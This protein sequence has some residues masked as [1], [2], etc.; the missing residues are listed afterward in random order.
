M[1]ITLLTPSA[2]SVLLG[3]MRFL[4]SSVALGRAS[5]NVRF[6]ST[7]LTTNKPHVDNAVGWRSKPS[8][9]NHESHT[10]DGGG[11]AHGLVVVCGPGSSGEEWPARGGEAAADASPDHHQSSPPAEEL[12][13]SPS[14]GRGDAR[15]LSAGVLVLPPS[16]PP[17]FRQRGRAASP[18]RDAG[19]VDDSTSASAGCSERGAP[20]VAL[21]PPPG[22]GYLTTPRQRAAGSGSH[23]RLSYW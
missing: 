1:A 20:L 7:G 5:S 9:P 12:S 17:A 10:E 8:Q 13:P 19:P 21:S 4:P 2:L 15:R 11:V 22:G 23:R 16:P 6:N 14:A 3:V 18:Q